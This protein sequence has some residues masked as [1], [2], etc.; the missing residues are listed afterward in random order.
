[1][2]LSWMNGVTKKSGDSSTSAI[3][4][5]VAQI[6]SVRSTSST[7]S[8][9]IATSPNVVTSSGSESLLPNQDRDFRRRSTASEDQG[10]IF[11]DD[12]VEEGEM[13]ERKL[14]AHQKSDISK[15]SVYKR[16]DFGSGDDDFDYREQINRQ[17]MIGESEA[18]PSSTSF[19]DATGRTLAL[20]MD[21][22]LVFYFC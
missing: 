12:D 8:L 13:K 18:M 9:K 14:S 5:S 2:L 4:T 21:R 6:G 16:E 10:E 15:Q 3:P 17:L 1:M 19:G 11:D 7:S 20:G 22:R